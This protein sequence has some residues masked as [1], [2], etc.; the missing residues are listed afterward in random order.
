VN[1]DLVP[2]AER[3]GGGGSA[4][5]SAELVIRMRVARV[6]FGSPVS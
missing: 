4:E 1:D 2:V 5:S 3:G 6:L